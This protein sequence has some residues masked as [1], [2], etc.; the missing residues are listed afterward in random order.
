MWRLL[1]CLL[2]MTV[3]PLHAE[4]FDLPRL[5]QLLQTG[6]VPQVAYTEKKYSALLAEPV[7]SAGTLAFR[8][9]DTVEKHMTAPRRESFVIT[10]EELVFTRNHVERRLPLSSQPLLAA[11]AASLRGVL[12]G[13]LGLLREH[14]RILL[15]GDELSWRLELLPLEA[16]AAR[17]VERIIVSGEGGRIRQIEVHERS[18]DRS[19]MQ[20]QNLAR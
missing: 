19:V 17:Y 7:S 11:F 14:Y 6:V 16:D 12:G 8:R 3:R 10:A 4:S 13:D 5:M 1:I 18:G 15:G 20:L 2:L 9:P